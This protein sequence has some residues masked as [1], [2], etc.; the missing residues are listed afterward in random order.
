M[1]M[2]R[3]L[4]KYLGGKAG[5]ADDLVFEALD[6]FF[7]MKGSKSWRGVAFFPQHQEWPREIGSMVTSHKGRSLVFVSASRILD[8]YSS[9]PAC[10]VKSGRNYYLLTR[11]NVQEEWLDTRSLTCSWDGF[12]LT[13]LEV[14]PVAEGDV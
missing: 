13:L 8:D 3:E 7:P 14:P 11:D 9:R 5:S 6:L 12:N 10:V 2:A 1:K 4:L